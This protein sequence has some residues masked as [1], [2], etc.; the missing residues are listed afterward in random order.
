MRRKRTSILLVPGSTRSGSTTV[1]ALRAASDEAGVAVPSGAI[2]D[3]LSRVTGLEGKVV[4]DATNDSPGVLMNTVG[5]ADGTSP[6]R[7]SRTR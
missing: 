4:I 6:S 1:A 2:D 7:R 5:S 3:A